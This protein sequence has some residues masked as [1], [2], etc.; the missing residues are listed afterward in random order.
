M[1]KVKHISLFFWLLFLFTG[2]AGLFWYN[3]LKF[4]LPTP[5]PAQY[6]RVNT[7][8]YIDL[9]SR[10]QGYENKPV[11]LHFFNPACPCSRFNMPHFKALAQ[12]YGDRLS[13]AVVVINGKNKYTTT[14][15]QQKFNLK[16]PVYFDTSIATLSGVYST[17]QAVL[18]DAHH[19][20]YYRGNY[21]KSRYC[22]D[23]QTNYAQ[24]A[25]NAFLNNEPSP[26][27]SAF[28]LTAYGCELPIC[29]K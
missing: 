2:I 17:P 23:K 24:I 22:T 19:N 26:V 6:H 21:N 27:N 25:I 28:A 18:L 16:I 15:I 10:V 29:K 8:T 4:N 1:V 7:G 9:N 20:L 12:Q 14:E 5:L 11:F 3:E 13:F